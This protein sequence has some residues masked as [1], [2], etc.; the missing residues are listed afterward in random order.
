MAAAGELG[1]LSTDIPE[2]FGG[3]GLDKISHRGA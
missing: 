3:L 2:E 1:L